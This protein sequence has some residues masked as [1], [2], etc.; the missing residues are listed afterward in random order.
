MKLEL[1]HYVHCPFCVRVRMA[2]G[3]LQLSHQTKVLPYD[4]E[5]TPVDLGG[6]KMLP[7][8]LIDDNPMYESLAI[9]KKVDTHNKLESHKNLS[10]DLDGVL[11]DIGEQVHSLAMPYWVWTPE[12]NE[13]SRQYFIAKK[14][15]KRGCFK[16]LARSRVKYER[17]LHEILAKHTSRLR[18]YWDSSTGPS[19]NDI[20]LAS[21]LWGMFVVPEFRFSQEWYDYLMQI[22][23]DC[24]FNYH[25]EYWK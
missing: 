15:Q 13:S 6:K 20:A 14:S 3:F 25:E 12:F 21:H 16:V 5:A 9:I 1:Y 17:R 18:P 22:K 2:L 23:Q 19:I 7:L 4:D 24:Q 10:T 11:Q 8:M